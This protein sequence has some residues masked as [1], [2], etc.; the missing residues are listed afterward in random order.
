MALA[1]DIPD[2]PLD[3]SQ[4]QLLER[5]SGIYPQLEDYLISFAVIAIFWVSCHHVFNYIKGS[6]ISIIYLNLLFLLLITLLSLTTSFVITYGSYQIPY[7]IY[8]VVVIL[9]SSL[10]SVI[11]LYVKRTSNSRQEYAS[12]IHT[13]YHV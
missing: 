7:L 3:I 12:F 11:W 4:S 13:R 9:T 2:L 10:L 6:H 8:C 1:I 5:L